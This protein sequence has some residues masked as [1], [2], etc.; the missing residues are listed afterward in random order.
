VFHA[1]TFG[2]LMTSLGGCR[3]DAPGP[4]DGPV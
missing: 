3:P 2:A 1:G 4:D